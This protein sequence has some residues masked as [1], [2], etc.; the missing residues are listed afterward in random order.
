MENIQ[1]DSLRHSASHVMA[2]A[3]QR[4]IDPNIELGVGPWIDNGFYHDFISKEEITSDHLKPLKKEMEKIIKEKQ[5]FVN[6]DVPLKEAKD[7][8]K[9][10]GQPYTLEMCEDLGEKWEK[11]I[12]FYINTIPVN[13][14]DKVIWHSLE[15]YQKKYEK[16]TKYFQ[17]MFPDLFVGKF[18]VFANMCKGPHLETT[19][20]IPSNAIKLAKIAGAYWKWDEKN[21]M[22]TRIYG[23]AFDKKD[24]LKKYVN[25]LEE[26]KKRDHRVLGKKLDLFTFSELVGPWL[27]LFTP[28]GTM[29]ID[30]L[31][32]K[33]EKICR[34][35]WFE[36]VMTPHLAKIELFQLSGHAEK[37][38]EELFHVTSERKQKY[39]MKPVQ[40]PHQTQI[41]A[42]HKRSYKEL[43]IRYMESN[44][45]YRAEKPGEI[46]GLSRV[47]AI[48]VED[49]HSFC[50]P[51][52]IKDE[53]KWMIN[54]IK[55][56]FWDLWLWWDHRVSLSLRDWSLDKYIGEDEDRKTAESMLQEVSNEMWLDAIKCEWEAAV[57]G[58]KLDFMFKDSLGREIQICTVQV[59]F[60]TPQ[61][62]KLTY[63]NEKGDNET[64][65]MIHRAI[66]GSYERLLVL[67]IEH[68]AWAFPMRLAPEQIR[69]VPVAEKFNKYAEEVAEK[70]KNN[71]ARVKL[72]DSTDSFSKKIRNGEIQK[73]PYLLIVWEKEEEAGSVNVRDRDTKKQK[74]VSLNEFL[75]NN[76]V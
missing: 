51:N 66:L 8:L 56:F 55:S 64:P 74:E 49:G 72:D 32:Q 19:W 63:T 9:I 43:P 41:Y 57:Y 3:I 30:L 17:D 26:A 4:N 15:G 14:S 69:I 48:T 45:Q 52:Q 71:G 44:K 65:V 36:K 5:E 58:P 34:K 10:L 29:I 21:V 37:Y 40:C 42:S 61:R 70:C 76:L 59:D 23:Y 38:P 33:I 62:F 73:I 24:E 18:V 47:V 25:F 20:E 16:V 53:V 31:Q 2:E 54:I 39:V 22:M 50:M 6:I 46:S 27:P 13:G 12:G 1:L 11:L 35:Y 75:E 28:K 60:A 67:L 7:I 68:F